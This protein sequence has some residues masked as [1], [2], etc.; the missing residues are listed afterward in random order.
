M[1]RVSFSCALGAVAR[2]NL[3]ETEIL[4][5]GADAVG[6]PAG[7]M[8]HERDKSHR[9]YPDGPRALNDDLRV[10][11][12]LGDRQS[13][14]AEPDGSSYSGDPQGVHAAPLTLRMEF[15]ERIRPT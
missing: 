14:L 3:S 1:Q 11:A 8:V 10:G 12:P 4:P 15:L 7:L 2:S 6:L 13:R 5:I 9:I